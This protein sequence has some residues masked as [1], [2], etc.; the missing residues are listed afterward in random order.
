MAAAG[1]S[2]LVQVVALLGAGVVAVPIF[3][4]LG[5]GSVLGYFAA[6]L[7][8]GPFGLKLFS[9]PA[10]I[11]HIAEFGVIMLLF[12]IGLEMQPSRLWGLRREI[13]GLGAGQVAASGALLTLAGYLSGLDLSVAF[14]AGMGFVLSSTA[15]VMQM[16]DE[17]GETST[18]QGQKAVSILLLEDLAI[19]PLLAIVAFIAPAGAAETS[20]DRVL[21]IG[22]AIGAIAGLVLAG[23]Y[24]LNPMFK[25]LAKA[26]AREVMTA[27]ALLVVLGSA[28][29][30]ALGGLSMAMGAFLAGVLLSEST[31]RHQLETDIEPFRGILLGLFFLAVGMSLDLSAIAAHWPTILGFTAL[32]IA[33]KSTAIFGVARALGSSNRE[34]IDRVALFAQGGEFAFVLYSAAA[35]VGIMDAPTNAIFTAVVILS[36]ALT[37]L[38]ALALKRLMPPAKQSLDGVDAAE[39]LTGQVLVIGFGRFAQVASQ[40]LLAR[41]F[42]IS[43]IETDV[44][45]IEAAATF[46]YKVYYGDGTRLDTLHA[47]GAGEAGA[48]LVC[49]DKQETSEKIVE[50]IKAEFPMA[51]LL[52]RAFDRGHAIDLIRTGVD[53]Q[54]RETFESAMTF[55]EAALVAL[56]VPEDEAAEITED[57]RRRDVERLD[58]QVAG[59]IHSGLDLLKGNA[60]V[61]TPL[62]KPRKEGK[63]IDQKPAGAEAPA[64][65]V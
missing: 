60:P 12:V 54:I 26:Q 18:A 47:S 36:M 22:I 3:K 15:V 14:V 23:R 65:A 39:G 9:D 2:E 25:I 38:T 61:P 20:S 58:L 17:R 50:L 37:P 5:L 16:L 30:M 45:M 8:I 13:F 59:D 41:G 52:V 29:L 11:L 1:Q 43:I 7:V 28:L 4:R 32:F 51:K 10:T 24:L 48:I 62:T 55:G 42:D 64:P 27:A 19:V 35:A 57:V 6:G 49:V 33:V 21:E 63:I 44:E 40:S 56:G 31:F 53:Y 34:G 46:G